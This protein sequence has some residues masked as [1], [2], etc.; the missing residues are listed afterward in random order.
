MSQQIGDFVTA[1]S[2][3]LA[4]GEPTHQE[5][6]FGW[7]RNELFVQLVEL[8]F[9]SIGLETDRVAALAVNDFVQNGIGDL[10]TVMREGFSHDFGAL[11]TNRQLIAW[12]RQYN[13]NHTPA[14]HL[15]FYGID[16]Q[17]ENTSAPSPR[18]YLE[19]ARDYVGLDIDIASVAGHDEQWSRQEAILDPEM[20]M[21]ES[22]A[23]GRLRSIADDLFDALYECAPQRIEATSRTEWHRAETHLTA[24]IGLL[25]YHKVAAQRHEQSERISLLLGARDVIMAQNLLAIRRIESRRGPT[26]VFANNTHLQRN[27]SH[28]SRAAGDITWTGAGSIAGSLLGE[29]Y[30][31][32]AGSLGRSDVCGLREPEPDTSEAFLDNRISTWGLTASSAIAAARSRTDTTPQQGYFPLDAATLDGSDAVLHISDG[33]AIRPESIRT[34]RG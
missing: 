5:P 20:S 16:A 19:Y 27:P 24:G 34:P 4:L 15:T 10:D 22:K 9:R 7:V 2:E 8:G 12:M 17:T 3:L 30:S 13:R 29:Q 26:L 14:A 21:G 6:A 32:I 11:D 18:R 28:F 33:A 25:R 1:S 31:F 23:A